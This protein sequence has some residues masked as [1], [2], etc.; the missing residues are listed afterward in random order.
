MT[1]LVKM[2]IVMI[3]PFLFV[4]VLTA[5][6]LADQPQAR[7]QHPFNFAHQGVF[8]IAALD[9]EFVG[10]FDRGG[11][12]GGGHH[13][14]ANISPEDL[15]SMFFGGGFPQQA[16]RRYARQ[17]EPGLIHSDFFFFK[18]CSLFRRRGRS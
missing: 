14:Q 9:H 16:R 12:F 5:S 15:F 11:P 6:Y 7:P 1:K 10:G 13:F 2:V 3:S 4:L 18:Y 17:Q 8:I